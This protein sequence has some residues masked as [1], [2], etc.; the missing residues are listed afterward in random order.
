MHRKHRSPPFRG[1]SR[2]VGAR[3]D[4]FPRAASPTGWLVFPTNKILRLKLFTDLSSGSTLS[5]CAMD[6]NALHINKRK[7][8]HG[9][10]I[11]DHPE[12][13]MNSRSAGMLDATCPERG[14]EY[15]ME[16]HK[17]SGNRVCT[18]V[19]GLFSKLCVPKRTLILGTPH[20]LEVSVKIAIIWE[21]LLVSASE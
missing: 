6:C 9:P 14:R 13:T 18:R 1:L 5:P 20:I 19:Y 21:G 3:T 16:N 2:R 10:Y 12:G 7:T 8:L 17:G 11:R 15:Q 4:V